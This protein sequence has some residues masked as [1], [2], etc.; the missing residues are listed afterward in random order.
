MPDA[1]PSPPALRV[2]DLTDELGAA[3]IRTLVG[4]GADVVR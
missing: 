2:L 4:I 1:P 3:A